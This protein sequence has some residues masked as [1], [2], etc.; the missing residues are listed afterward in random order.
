MK[1]IEKA[2]NYWK[3]N[4]DEI[5]LKAKRGLMMAGVC[6]LGAAVGTCLD[7]LKWKS[8][9]KNKYITYDSLIRAE[10]GAC[11]KYFNVGKSVSLLSIN[12]DA[13]PEFDTILSQAADTGY[14]TDVKG[15]SRK[16]IGAIIYGTDEVA[17]EE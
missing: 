10:Q 6:I 16:V 14:V 9:T 8:L 13:D 5:V 11:G 12:R 17:K 4:K 3:E 2:K 1:C 7:E 15:D